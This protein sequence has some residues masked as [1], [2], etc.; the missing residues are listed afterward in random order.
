[1]DDPKLYQHDDIQEKG[2]ACIKKLYQKE[3][4][5][6][7]TVQVDWPYKTLVPFHGLKIDLF[8]SPLPFYSKRPFSHSR[9]KKTNSSS[10]SGS[11]WGSSQIP[12]FRLH[13]GEREK[14]FAGGPV[15][16]EHI[17]RLLYST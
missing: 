12:L 13:Q 11:N 17:R 1:M 4:G 8:F 7:S 2:I 16:L 5:Q 6:I 9:L 15:Q 10:I 3:E 14:E